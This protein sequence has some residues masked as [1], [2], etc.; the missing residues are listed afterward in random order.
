MATTP[1][2]PADGTTAVNFEAKIRDALLA[3]L[4]R[5][6]LT[7]A[8]GGQLPARVRLTDAQRRA[9]WLGQLSSEPQLTVDRAKGLSGDRL[10][11]AAQGFSFR[12][13]GSAP[14][15]IDVEVSFAVYI[16]LHAS[17]A[18]QRAFTNA[19]T[20]NIDTSAAAKAAAQ[21]G[22]KTPGRQLAAVWMKVPVG[23]VNVR[24]EV[25]DGARGS[26]RF[27]A[28]AIADAIRTAVRPA[29]GSGPFRPRRTASPAGSL[30]RDPDMADDTAWASYCANNLIAAADATLPQF[31]AAL[32][33]D[34]LATEAGRDVL[35]TLVNTTP[36]E[37]AQ[38]ADQARTTPFGRKHLDTRLYEV[39][40]AARTDAALAPYTLEQVAN[41]HRYDRTVPAFGQASPVVA[42][43]G[44]AT[45][46][47]TFETGY[48]AT[49]LTQRPHPRTTSGKGETIDARFDAVIADPIGAVTAI[50]DAHAAW[51]ADH[52]SD[53]ALTARATARGWSD[54]AIAE[55]K[56]DADTARDEVEWI[57]AGVRTIEGDEVL[58][59]AFVLANRAMKMVGASKGYDS[60]RLFQIA[61]MV[62]CLPAV[63][64]PEAD[65][66]VQIETVQTGG[67]KSEAYLGV[68]LLHLFHA[69]LTGGTAGVNVW[70]RFPL[71]LLSTQQ[72]ARFAEAVFAAEVLR[73]DDPRISAGDP[74]GVG[75]F[76]GSTDTPNRIYAANSRF[77]NG[78]D[79]HSPKLAERCRVLEHCPACDPS[80]SGRKL[81]VQFD[82]ASWTMRHT[83]QNPACP[84][85]GV[86]PIW[87]V[88]DDIYRNAPSVLV[89]TVDRLAQIAQNKA[90][91]IIFGQAQSRCPR[92]G[93]TSDPSYCAV[94]G[95][96]APRVP[97][98]PGFGSLRCE[99]AD[100]LHLLEESLGALD[101][102]YETLLQQIG[103][104]LRNQPL[105]IV[106]ATATL[107]GYENQVRHLYQR[108][109]RRFPAPGPDAGETFFSYTDPEDPLRRYVGV[110][111]RGITMVTAAAEVTRMYAAWLERSIANPASAAADAGLDHAEPHVLA[112]VDK[113]LRDDYAVLLGY[114]LRNEDL[115]SYTRD[116]RVRSLIETSDNLAII[117]GSAEPAAVREAVRRLGAPPEDPSRRIRLIAATRAIGHG[118][119]SPRL[120]VMV[121]MGTPTQAAE[122][123]QA[124]ARVG[125]T[126]PGLIVHI[127]NP[128]RDRDA[129]I[130]RY[131]T[132]WITYL[133]R[134]VHK[135]PVN[136]ESL[137]V[138]RRVLSGAL[139]AWTLQVYEVPWS[140]SGK[141]RYALSKSDQF[142]KALD[143]GFLDRTRLIEDLSAGLG[144]NPANH[145]HDMHRAE[146]VRYVDE[147]MSVLAVSGESNTRTADLLDPS[148]PRSL[149]DIEAPITI[150]GNV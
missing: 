50:V 59:E 49:A 84:L 2:A 118:F 127:F 57:R 9:I 100:E 146:V 63:A 55:A 62:G 87:V 147:M 75:F 1:A 91:Q 25:H 101:G 79:P 98:P 12:L 134:L 61:W 4:E 64:D 109:A 66:S 58:R 99:I 97:I 19:L 124:T 81:L 132:A 112:V 119:D 114:C 126:H 106:A 23:P 29:S 56:R 27:G 39:R 133:D 8:A 145:Y 110:R 6:I 53:T 148:V 142:R 44:T 26:T 48:G 108:S 72:T 141:G 107:E 128:S 73:R 95:C 10:V 85:S 69:R 138:L 115:S 31:A 149:R 15:E 40:V 96:K 125:R 38:F 116:D 80:G 30:P 13:A 131:Y 71:R 51:V 113:A 130:F 93:Y 76:V 5:H 129:S 20:D 36:P 77:S 90:F 43:T 33:V 139:M 120:G 70:A 3:S 104:R 65:P 16:A 60:W 111:P 88:D 45:G 28:Q 121:L 144:L 135:V 42:T 35:I 83:C 123:I 41:S 143:A 37:D 34:V 47:T 24:V 74:F 82:E 67:G 102:M 52:W 11:P 14:A 18:E 105:H 89:G 7:E 92:H 86:L 54:E 17:Q 140:T 150:H 78:V 94:F 22:G 136:R 117:S 68:M 21:V 122:V 46:V 137:P 103:A 32:D